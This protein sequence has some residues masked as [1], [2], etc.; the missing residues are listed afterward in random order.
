MSKAQRI[1]DAIN[2]FGW[3]PLLPMAMATA[4][5]SCSRW[6]I[7]RAVAAGKLAVAGKRGR[8]ITFRRDDL[9]RWMTGSVANS[10]SPSD[11]PPVRL[12]SPNADAIARLRAITK[13]RSA[14]G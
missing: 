2:A 6:T 10:E 14:N 13:T 3:P 4:Y 8:S 11:P 1:S 5:A 9:D 12:A 7:Q